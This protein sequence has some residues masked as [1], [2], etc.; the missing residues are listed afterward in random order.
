MTW[1]GPDG[2][3]E[4]LHPVSEL[5]VLPENPRQGDI[6]AISDSLARFGQLKPIVIDDDGVILA[7]NHTY[8]AAVALGWTKVAAVTA[9][10][11]EGQEKTAFA[12]ADNR[13]SD[14]ASYDNEMLVAQLSALNNLEGTGY[15]LEDVEEL[16]FDLEQ[17]LS[18][19]EVMDGW[20]GLDEN[21][22][23]GRIICPHCGEDF[24]WAER[25]KP[26]E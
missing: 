1:N 22:G 4:M 14:L 8:K 25:G 17:P 2:L 5:I 10:E 3:A 20:S 9:D 15:Q 24:A 19:G 7:G 26:S 18:F 12:L 11:L 6:G 16:Q 13:L 23:T 21:K